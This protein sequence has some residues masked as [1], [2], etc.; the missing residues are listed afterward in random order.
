MHP[1]DWILVTASLLLVVVIGLYTQSYVK[2]VA[3][4]LS[5]GRVARR[6]LLAVAKGEMAAGSVVYVALFEVIKHSGF[7]T[8]WWGYIGGPITIL[9]T[10]SGFVFYRYRETRAMTVGQFFEIRYSRSFRLFT[11]M[12]AF[13]AG[14]LNFGI[15][16]AVGAR[17]MV[18]L[19]GLPAELPILGG[20]LPTYIPLMAVLLAINLFITLS[21]GLVTIIMTN[22]AEGIISQILNLVLIFG[23]LSMFTWSQIS[24][25]LT[26]HPAGQSFINPFD[27]FAQKDFNVWF[28]LMGIAIWIYTTMA[29]QNQGAYNSAP[30]TAHEARMGGLLGRLRSMGLGAGALLAIC[31]MTYLHDPHFAAGAA[32][33][34]TALA[35]IQDPHLRE[36]MEI[37]IAI[38]TLLPA[39]LKGSLCVILL[40][41]AIGG[42]S[43]HLHSWGSI[44][45][46]DVILPY[47]KKAF[48]TG[49][50]LQVLRLSII[51]V[52]LFAFVFGA[53]FHQME[54]I[55]MWWAISGSI[56]T[57]GAGVAIIGGL[58]WKKGTAAGAWSGLLTGSLLSVGG[59]I[60]REI[61]QDKIPFNGTQIAFGTMLIAIAVYAVVS[62]LTCR[63]NFNMDRM[64]HRGA[65]AVIKDQVGEAAMRP[66]GRKINWGKYIGY[67]ENFTLGDKWI[68]GGLFGWSMLFTGV[69]IFGSIAY[70]IHPWPLWVWSEYW[71][72]YVV[73][74]PA[75]FAAVIAVWFT[76]GGILDVKVLFQKLSSEKVNPLDNGAVANHQNRDE[77]IVP[78]SETPDKAKSNLAGPVI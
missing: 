63:E 16:P 33:V 71:H 39:G 26:D 48:S 53:F 45:V 7:S 23:L 70:L 11:G 46:Q 29:W 37:P 22:C 67:D 12:L 5:A 47:R 58:Y 3:D 65:Y 78:D 69:G 74:I 28:T 68:A 43:N 36:Q 2:S 61:Y 20:M 13:S 54:Y 30:L 1:I 27:S 57:G 56:F 34:H 15:I 44:L 6:Y 76:W 64:L 75:V 35:K 19:L 40:L 21:G 14:L 41:G 59:I 60:A 55:M 9:V 51:G 32:Q 8:W 18:Y 42:D 4:F 17:F 25:T 31:A 50:H 72:Y 38:S 77:K 49:M 73:V 10:I 52:A 66:A 24:G 62:L